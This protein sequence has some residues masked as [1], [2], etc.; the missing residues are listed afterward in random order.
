MTQKLLQFMYEHPILFV[1][2]TLFAAICTII[3]YW[4]TYHNAKK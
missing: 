2:V 4:R 1:G 3:V